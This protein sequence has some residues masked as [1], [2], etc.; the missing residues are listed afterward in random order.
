[1]ITNDTVPVLYD[2]LSR[3]VQLANWL[4]YRDRFASFTMHKTLSVQ[5]ATGG[6][7]NRTAGLD[8]VNERLLKAV[9]LPAAPRVLDAGCG[10]GGTIFHWHDRIGGVYDGLTL[11]RVQLRVAR[12]EARRRGTEQACRFHLKSYDAPINERYDA[13]VAI[14]SLVHAPDINQ[15]IANLAGGL[16]PGGLM[17]MLEDMAKVD[18][19][20]EAPTDAGLLRVHWGCSP[21]PTQENY[22]E[23]LERARLRVIHEE[24]LTPHVRYRSADIL[25]RQEAKYSRLYKWIRLTPVRTVLSAYLGGVGLERLYLKGKMSYQLIVARKEA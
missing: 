12:R 20:Q 7:T 16:R 1:L 5:A 3:Y 22:R 11:S 18:L 10:F 4:S 9:Q 19:E 25:D 24:D 14:E 15:T 2:W 8:Y 17:L 13:V 23:A 21:Y 6:P